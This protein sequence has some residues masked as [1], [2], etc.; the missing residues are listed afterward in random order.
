[1]D[2]SWKIELY[3]SQS[4]EIPVKEFIDG[5]EI[6]AQAK[7]HNTLE[8]LKQYGLQTGSTRTKKLTGTDFWELRILGGDNLRIFYIAVQDKT[9]LLIHGFKKKS[10]KTPSKEIKI[11]N[12]RLQEYRSKKSGVA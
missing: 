8:L 2:S 11:A 3:K 7:V 4:G 5:L 1:M 10:Q 12:L 9:F 6:R